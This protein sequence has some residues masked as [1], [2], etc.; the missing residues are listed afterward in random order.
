MLRSLLSH[1]IAHLL[2][3]SWCSGRDAAAQR[4]GREERRVIEV[5]SYVVD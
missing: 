2:P 3:R 1:R 4:S 5:A